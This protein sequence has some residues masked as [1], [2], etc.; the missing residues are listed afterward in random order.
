MDD[1]K[2]R[3]INKLDTKKVGYLRRRILTVWPDAPPPLPA[4]STA[5]QVQVLQTA[6]FAALRRQAKRNTV[7]ITCFIFIFMLL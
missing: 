2:G 3:K 1:G 6:A 7:R 5:V 4:L